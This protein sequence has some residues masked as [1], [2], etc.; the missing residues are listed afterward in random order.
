MVAAEAVDCPCC[1]LDGFNRRIQ[2]ANFE[3]RG[4]PLNPKGQTAGVETG[5][6]A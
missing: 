3:S 2:S 5:C 6:C 1:D 4:C